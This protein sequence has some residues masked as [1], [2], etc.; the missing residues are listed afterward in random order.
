MKTRCN[1]CGKSFKNNTCHEC[2]VKHEGYRMQRAGLVVMSRGEIDEV[3]TTV[4]MLAKNKNL[5]QCR[6]E[7]WD[8]IEGSEILM[9]G[10]EKQG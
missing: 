7:V 3:V 8:R 10:S 5:A 6:R 9:R 2:I 4:F 1:A